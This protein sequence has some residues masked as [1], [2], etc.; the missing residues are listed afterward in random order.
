ML[1]SKPLKKLQKTKKRVLI[2]ITVC[3]SFRLKTFLGDI[4]ALFQRIRNSAL[5]FAFYDTHIEV[6]KEKKFVLLI[7]ALSATFKGRW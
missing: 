5:N 2:F 4:F 7:L 1:I 3:K 6:L